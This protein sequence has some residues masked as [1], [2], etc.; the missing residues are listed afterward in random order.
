[1]AYPKFPWFMMAMSGYS[2]FSHT[3][4]PMIRWLK[5]IQ[6]P[7]VSWVN[8]HVSSSFTHGHKSNAKDSAP[9]LQWRSRWLDSHP[10]SLEGPLSQRD[11]IC[12]AVRTLT[13]R[14]APLVERRNEFVVWVCR[15]WRQCKGPLAKTQ[16]FWTWHQFDLGPATMVTMC[17]NYM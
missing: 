8:S 11:P 4:K 3:P 2:P 15:G 10:P 1:M 5:I 12:G 14:G 17:N 6:I 16:L 13:E 7:H 9:L